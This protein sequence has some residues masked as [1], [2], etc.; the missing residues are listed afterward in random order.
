MFTLPQEQARDDE[1]RDHEEHVDADVTPAQPGSGVE[2]NDHD[3]GDGTQS[4]DVGAKPPVSG[5]GAGLVDDRARWL[6]GCCERGYHI[7]AWF[8][9]MTRPKP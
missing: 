6:H 8:E 9:D 4:L 5:W 2:E 3:D 7:T 1:T